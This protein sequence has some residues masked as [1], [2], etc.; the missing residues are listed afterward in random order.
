MTLEQL[1]NRQIYIR[2]KKEN[3]VELRSELSHLGARFVDSVDHIIFYHTRLNYLFSM[4]IAKKEL[5]KEFKGD[6]K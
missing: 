6:Q 1:E 5:T 3:Y 2:Q 4:E